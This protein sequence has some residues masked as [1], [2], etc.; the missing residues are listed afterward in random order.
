V[1]KAKSDWVFSTAA[2]VN[3]KT[4]SGAAMGGPQAWQAV[5]K[6]LGGPQRTMAGYRITPVLVFWT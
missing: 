6:L 3:T 2:A 4:K 1:R 5:K